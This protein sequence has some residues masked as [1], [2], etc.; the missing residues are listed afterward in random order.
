M[1]PLEGINHTLTGDLTR[2]GGLCLTGFSAHPE[3]RASAALLVKTDPEGYLKWSEEFFYSHTGQSLGYTGR[4]TS[5]GGC[6]FTG[7]AAVSGGED[8]DMLLVKVKAEGYR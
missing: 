3:R 1:L 4:T 7:H 5:D 8:L 2:D 6:V